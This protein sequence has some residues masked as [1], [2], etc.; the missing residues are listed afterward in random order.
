M[1]KSGLCMVHNKTA[2]ALTSRF[3]VKDCVCMEKRE[4]CECVCILG[5]LQ[6]SQHSKLG[7]RISTITK[8]YLSLNMSLEYISSSG[9]Y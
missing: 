8:D 4:V 6:G 9:I 2:L 5:F 7:H 3:Y 1:R